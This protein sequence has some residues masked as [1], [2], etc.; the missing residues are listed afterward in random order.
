MDLKGEVDIINKINSC[1]IDSN[2]LTD[3]IQYDIVIKELG[4]FRTIFKSKK[5]FEGEPKFNKISRKLFNKKKN[6]Y[7]L[8]IFKTI[9]SD[10]FGFCF[11]LNPFPLWQ[12]PFCPNSNFSFLFTSNT[13]ILNNVWDGDIF[14][15]DGPLF[16]KEYITENELFM[17]Q[18]YVIAKK[19]FVDD[20][21]N[22]SEIYYLK[23]FL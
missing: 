18:N 8:A 21:I 1:N 2:I 9:E 23:I 4:T 15:K 7:R 20:I 3:K 10:I 16:I 17:I 14:I 12:V 19:K 11:K 6:V 22:Y 5:I 13:E